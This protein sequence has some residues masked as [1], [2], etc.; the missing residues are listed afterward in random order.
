MED[1]PKL[2][3]LRQQPQ[4]TAEPTPRV[5]IPPRK[6]KILA[7]I[8]TILIPAF[9]VTGAVFAV[10]TIGDN[11]TTTGSLNAKTGGSATLVVAASDASPRMKAQADYVADGTADN[12]EIQAAI[13]VLPA[14][15]G[16]VVLSEG[17]FTIADTITMPSGIWLQGQG[18]QTIV[19]NSSNA[20]N[21]VFESE[22]LNE[23][24]AVGAGDTDIR[25]SDMTIDAN[26]DGITDGVH[27]IQFTGTK[28][29]TVENL[30]LIN[31]GEW[32]LAIARCQNV[33][34]NNIRAESAATG[35]LDGVHLNGTS[36]AIVDGVQGNTGDDLVAVTS[37]GVDISNIIVRNVRGTSGFANVMK[38]EVDTGDTGRNIVV[39]G[40][41][42]DQPAGRTLVI[43]N[44]GGT[45][46]NATFTNIVA[47]QG[48]APGDITGSQGIQLSGSGVTRNILV[49]ANI[50]GPSPVSGGAGRA[51]N[52]N[53]STLENSEFDIQ[54]RDITSGTQAVYFENVSGSRI[55]IRGDYVNSGK[56]PGV[57][58]LI[59]A[60]SNNVITGGYYKGGLRSVQLGI[61]GQGSSNNRVTNNVFDGPTQYVLREQGSSDNNIYEGNTFLNN[62]GTVLNSLSASSIVRHN[63]GFATESSGTAT[64]T[65]GSTSVTVSHGLD[66]TP[67][68]GDC[69]FVG[70]E[71]PTNDVGTTWIDTYT[72][73]EM[74]LNVEN[75]PGASNFD[76]SWSCQ[77]L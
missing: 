16:K 66:V 65:S 70:A 4:S 64:I 14:G 76:V 50:I 46:E 19:K 31:G 75:D 26:G 36:D 67:S 69:S 32:A 22:T 20:A 56:S 48:G 24:I 60:G 49:Q 25:L 59:E 34:V 72:S 77:V 8:L 6:L 15:G 47:H 68:A 51:L 55:R 3:N 45:L 41:I 11:I 10:T 12:I 5:A 30:R 18:S 52:S 17:T 7:T 57:I 42:G 53:A 38:V 29:L 2:I 21:H 40:V 33:Y 43:N 13:D 39:N 35:T 74:N 44:G 54:F 63:Q 61:T 23:Q 58:L 28:R 9:V 37:N 73:T 62:P 1:F 27:T 71:N